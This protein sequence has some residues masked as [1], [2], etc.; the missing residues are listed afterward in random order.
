MSADQI[1]LT[2]PCRAEF[3]KTVRM[4]ASALVSRTAAT[5][6]DL[7]DVRMAA[8]EIFVFAC[9]HASDDS[10]ITVEF[11]LA[12]DEVSM[13]VRLEAADRSAD[14][15]VERRSAYASFILQS[16]TDHMEF[17]SDLEGQYLL[18]T[19]RL[20]GEPDDAGI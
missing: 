16:V 5:Y 9:D 8:E 12:A 20:A 15:E 2:V 14:E 11:E 3:A 13:K 4:T 18:V 19:K 7:D 6:D 10:Q 17:S 1:T